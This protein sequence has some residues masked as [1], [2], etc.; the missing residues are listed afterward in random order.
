MCVINMIKIN[1]DRSLSCIL[2]TRLCKHKYEECDIII[3]GRSLLLE[4]T[5]LNLLYKLATV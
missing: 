3:D 4:S 2:S 1:D 5:L